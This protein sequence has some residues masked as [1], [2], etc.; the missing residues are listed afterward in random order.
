MNMIEYKEFSELKSQIDTLT[1]LIKR[2]V[3]VEFNIE[4]H[5]TSG[6]ASIYIKG[7]Y[8]AKIDSPKEFKS[9]LSGF[10]ECINIFI[11]D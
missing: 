3:N 8:V 4:F 1:E 2:K 5:E 10:E 7:K 9:W 6:I 11:K